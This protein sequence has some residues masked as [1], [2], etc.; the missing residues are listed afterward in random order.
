MT[1]KLWR[2]VG[3]LSDEVLAGSDEENVRRVFRARKK[4]LRTMVTTLAACLCICII[5]GMCLLPVIM[6]GHYGATKPAPGHDDNAMSPGNDKNTAAL[7]SVGKTV[8]V[9]DASLTFCFFTDGQAVFR[10]ENTQDAATARAIM[11]CVTRDGEETVYTTRDGDFT[12]IVN[13]SAV[14]DGALPA[15]RG[16][17]EITVDLRGRQAENGTPT[18]IE[19]ENFGRFALPGA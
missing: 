11:L 6:G 17:Y 5:A 16:T 9:G 12:V 18:A 4:R 19:I 10:L 14:S 1:E 15:A 13:G 2:A 3:A 7:F 8:T